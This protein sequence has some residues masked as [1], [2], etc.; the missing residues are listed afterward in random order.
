MSDEIKMAVKSQQ[1][2]GVAPV[3]IH[4]GQMKQ[5]PIIQVSKIGLENIIVEKKEEVN[6]IEIDAFKLQDLIDACA[7]DL[8]EK[9]KINVS[10]AIN[11]AGVEIFSFITVYDS[12]N[13]IF[14][15]EKDVHYFNKIFGFKNLDLADLLS[16]FFYMNINKYSSDLF[17]AI[18]ESLPM[19]SMEA[20]PNNRVQVTIH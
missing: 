5:E 16:N 3:V 1:P 6:K 15:F 18:P 12:R 4:T 7:K 10:Q 13:R 8:A 20:L 11:P 17:D 9:R 14:Q 19:T 2:V